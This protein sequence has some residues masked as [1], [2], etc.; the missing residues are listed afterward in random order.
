MCSYLVYLALWYASLCVTV[1]HACVYCMYVSLC[2]WPSACTLVPGMSG[3]VE[4]M[5]VYMFG[6]SVYSGGVSVPVDL[7]VC[8]AVC[9]LWGW[10]PTVTVKS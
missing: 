3:C 1:C 9:G 4:C 7:W 6:E 2:V 5:D 10:C 8:T